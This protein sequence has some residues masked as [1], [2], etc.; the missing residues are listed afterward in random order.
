MKPKDQILARMYVVLTLLSILPALVVLQVLRIHAYD[1]AELRKKGSDQA[2][3]AQVIPAVRGAILDRMGR[4]LAVNAARWDLA[5]DPTIPGFAAERSR[6]IANMS[7]LTGAS[8]AAIARSIDRR[9]SLKYVLLR[10]GLREGAKET[11]ESWNVPGVILH[12]DYARRYNYGST[13]SH[14][15]GHVDADGNGTAGLELRYNDVLRGS[16]GRR[17]A[18]RDRRGKIKAYVDGSVVEPQDGESL[19]LTVDLIRQTIVEEELASGVEESGS[20]WGTAIAMDP[21]TGA[22]LAMA[23]FPTYDPNQPGRFPTEARR[24]HAIT[25]RIE[26]G[27]TFKLVSAIASLEQGIV[28]LDDTID[29]GNGFRVFG[30]RHLHDTHGHGRI[31]FE[32]AISVSSNIGIAESVRGLDE[33]DLYQY[34][35]NLGFGQPTWVDLPGEVT[36]VLKKPSRWSGTTKTS[37]SIGYEVEAT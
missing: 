20:N 28:S 17:I 3:S 26:P 37:I 36:G 15:L 35:R 22:V 10:R 21:N 5:L 16:D 4:T 11:V 18:K 23:N 27:S 24:N 29:T 31:S 6:F 33:G 12:P 1:G 9:K 34:A 32:E 13:L 30:R 14:V 8:N 19:V 7:R 2:S 25:D